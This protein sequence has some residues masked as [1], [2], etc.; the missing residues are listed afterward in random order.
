MQNAIHPDRMTAPER[1]DEVARIL[2]L[3]IGRLR[4]KSSGTQR[5]SSLDFS[6]PQRVHG[7]EPNKTDE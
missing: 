1:L 6:A 4:A 7:L 2:C 3:G 5:E